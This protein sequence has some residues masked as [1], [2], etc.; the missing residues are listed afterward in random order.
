MIQVSSP[1]KL[2]SVEAAMRSAAQR[3]GAQLISVINFGHL[4]SEKVRPVSP[5][6]IVFSLCQPDLTA[7]LLSADP[8]FAALLPCRVAAFERDGA[9]TLETISPSDFCRMLN[10]PDLDR[11]SL[12][13]ETTLLEIMEETARAA[14]EST[15]PPATHWRGDVGATEEQ[16]NFRRMVPQRIDRR[17][18][19]VEEVAGTGQH[20]APGG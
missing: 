8:R 19:K 1:L 18:T 12:L 10:R 9:V 6:A 7:N 15:Q 4:Y 20:D 11:L 3:H 14:G 5:G 2:D 16:V 13:L 17:G